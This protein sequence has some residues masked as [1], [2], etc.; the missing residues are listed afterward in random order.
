MDA[1]TI[2]SAL[3]NNKDD[4]VEATYRVLMQWRDSETD[5]VIAYKHICEAL[6]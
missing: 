5:K 3:Q 4:I 2:D 1:V 6:K